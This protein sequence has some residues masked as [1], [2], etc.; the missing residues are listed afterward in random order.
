MIPQT[1]LNTSTQDKY[2]FK[3]RNDGLLTV[4]GIVKNLRERGPSVGHLEAGL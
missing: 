3:Q 1:R 2:I 4:I